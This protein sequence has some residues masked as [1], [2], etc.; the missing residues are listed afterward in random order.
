MGSWVLLLPLLWLT[1]TMCS[2]IF[3]IKS[4]KAF[5]LYIIFTFI[6]D[7]LRQNRY[8]FACGVVLW[9]LKKLKALS[10][11]FKHFA[12]TCGTLFLYY[13]SGAGYN[14]IKVASFGYGSFSGDFPFPLPVE[15]IFAGEDKGQKMV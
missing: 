10:L 2:F 3:I 6:V 12:F 11:I 5:L 7:I 15:T 8:N 14:G 13:F 4:R 9:R 1:F